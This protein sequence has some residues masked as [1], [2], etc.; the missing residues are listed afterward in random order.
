MANLNIAERRL[1]QDGRIQTVVRGK[2]IDLRVSTMPTLDGESVVLRV[3]DRESVALDFGSLGIEGHDLAQLDTMLSNPNGVLLVTG[4][5]GSGKTTTLYAAL[6]QLNSPEKKILTVE[7]PIEYRLSGINQVQ[8]KPSIGLSFAH[9][10][11]AMLRQDPDIIMI[12]EIRDDETAEIAVQ[13]ALT[14]HLVLSTLHTNDAAS[15]IT[16]LID[17][18][19][20]D[21]LLTSTLTGV[22]AQRL[23]RRLCTHC[24]EEVRAMPEVV[25]QFGLD[26]LR[27]NGDVVLYRAMGC[28]RCGHR[29]FAGRTTITEVLVMTDELR[30]LIVRG[31]GAH[32]LSR[33]ASDCGMT[34]MLD[35][36][37]AKAMAG[38]TTLEEVLRVTRE[39]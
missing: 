29:G 24:R 21:F 2:V 31:A 5:T 4:P 33:A 25:E 11:R 8:V 30:Q 14:G 22:V 6:T 19:V 39:K 7:D 20:Q 38:A 23:V 1:P 17:M 36:G 9:V 28:E 10:L 26:R 13:A 32:D 15:T 18:G 3:L 34:T 12:G 35:N 37:L 27:H 16:R